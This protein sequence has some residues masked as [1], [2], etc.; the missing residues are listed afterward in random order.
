MSYSNGH[1]LLHSQREGQVS[2]FQAWV[3]VL[4]PLCAILFQVYVPLFFQFASFLELPLATV[5]YFALMRRNQMTG[6][7]LGAAVG[8]VQDSLSKNPLGMFGIVKTLVGYWA[9][10]IGVRIDV[11]HLAVRGLITFFFYV[12][13][14]VLYWVLERALLAHQPGFEIQRWLLMGVLNAI[15]GVA[16]FR[17]LDRLRRL[18]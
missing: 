16:L 11:D 5:V 7:L 6:L 13:H 9:A 4:V 3:L 17:F 18:A 14:Q 2:R 1:L 12:I 8:L 10:S 15:V